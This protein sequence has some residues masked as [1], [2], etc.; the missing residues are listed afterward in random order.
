MLMGLSVAFSALL[1]ISVLKALEDETTAL[2]NCH[3]EESFS[4]FASRL[5][6]SSTLILSSFPRRSAQ[7]EGY[8]CSW[9]CWL[10]TSRR[11]LTLGG[12]ESTTL[13]PPYTQSP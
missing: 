8:L 10:T 2:V 13:G 11:N 9:S 12:L 3:K 5:F 1:Y 6:H 4:R 7:S